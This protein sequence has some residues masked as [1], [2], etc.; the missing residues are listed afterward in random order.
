MTPKTG[1]R[2]VLV[3]GL[4]N[5][6]MGDDGVGV[7]VANDLEAGRLD[8]RYALPAEIEIVDG[9]TLGLDLLVLL[10]EASSL[11]LIDAI[12]CGRPPGTVEVLSGA[13]L[14]TALGS[15]ISPHEVGL[16]DLLAAAR[17]TGSMPQRV[18]LVAVQPAEIAPGWHLS[19]A[20]AAAVPVAAKNACR[21]VAA[22]ATAGA[23]EPAG[24]PG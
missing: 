21:E 12:E 5:V 9:G 7:A 13:E 19:E 17:L 2:H 11:V 15:R 4:G 23:L 10:E 24:S 16:A 20:V 1:R 3:L 14:D 22:W 18:V 8:G 6:L